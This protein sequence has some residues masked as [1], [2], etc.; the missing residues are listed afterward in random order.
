MYENWTNGAVTTSK[1]IY[2]DLDL[3][4]DIYSNAVLYNKAGSSEEISD[5]KA[6]VLFPTPRDSSTYQYYVKN[7]S[8]PGVSPE[9]YVRVLSEGKVSLYRS[10]III[11]TEM[12]EINAGMVKTFSKNTRYFM[13]K[14]GILQLV[15]NTKKDVLMALRDKGNEIEKFIEA[16]ELSLRKEEHLTEVFKYYNTL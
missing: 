8:G 9:Q 6:F 14:D 16:N 4:V 1:G 2:K 10:D 7:I 11:V 13:K 12:S 15:K 3:K 5:I